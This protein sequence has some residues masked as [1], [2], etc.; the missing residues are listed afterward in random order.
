[1]LRHV[2]KLLAGGILAGHLVSSLG[3]TLREEKRRPILEDGVGGGEGWE[4]R[5][6]GGRRRDIV[7]VATSLGY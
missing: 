2:Y 6:E 7:T 5:V 3:I 1:M 4:L